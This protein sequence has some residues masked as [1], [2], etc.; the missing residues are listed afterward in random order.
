MH[1]SS[2]KEGELTGDV[3]VP[4]VRVAPRAARDA[5][6]E[7][8]DVQPRQL[9]VEVIHKVREVP[10]LKRCNANVARVHKY[11]PES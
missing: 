10:V 3:D 5:E 2:A 11:S 6:L 9:D 8:G 7:V 1:R 4:R